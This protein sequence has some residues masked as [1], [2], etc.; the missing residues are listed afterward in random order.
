MFHL[1][2]PYQRRLMQLLSAC[3]WDG[4]TSEHNVQSS[5]K[6][7]RVYSK[8]KLLGNVCRKPLVWCHFFFFFRKGGEGFIEE[9][10]DGLSEGEFGRSHAHSYLPTCL[11]HLYLHTNVHSNQPAA[12]MN[13]ATV[14]LFGVYYNI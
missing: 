11:C 3:H 12:T 5:A 6:R 1:S 10:R 8:N 7:K 13:E 14:E 2:I 9:K 4:V